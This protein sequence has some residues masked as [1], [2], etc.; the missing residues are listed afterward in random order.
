MMLPWVQGGED[1]AASHLAC[2]GP[3]PALQ[4]WAAGL[5]SGQVL[6]AATG[7][8]AGTLLPVV[9]LALNKQGCI[10]TAAPCVG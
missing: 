6:G 7:P 8:A 3:G 10:A 9:W 4:L 2:P 5:S 1:R